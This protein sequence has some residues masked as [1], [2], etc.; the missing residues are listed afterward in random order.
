MMGFHHEEWCQILKNMGIR[1]ANQ[2]DFRPGKGKTAVLT[3]GAW[4]KR[5]GSR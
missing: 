5:I 3:Q 2:A 1:G 4:V